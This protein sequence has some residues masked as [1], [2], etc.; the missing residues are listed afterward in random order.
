MGAKLGSAKAPG[1]WALGWTY[2]DIGADSEIGTFSDSDFGGGGTDVSGHVLQGE[3]AVSKKIGLGA[4]VFVNQVDRFQG[5]EH[6]HRRLQ[7][8]VQFKFE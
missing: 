8:D 7:L 6:D 5:A 4:T 2:R 1:D 3:Y